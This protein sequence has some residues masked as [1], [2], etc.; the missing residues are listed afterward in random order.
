[1]AWP[2]GY[3]ETSKKLREYHKEQAM[4]KYRH[5]KQCEIITK[6]L[7]GITQGVTPRQT[8]KEMVESSLLELTVIVR[9]IAIDLAKKWP[10]EEEARSDTW[11]KLVERSEGICTSLCKLVGVSNLPEARMALLE[12]LRELSDVVRL[13]ANRAKDSE[14]DGE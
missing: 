9:D 2:D 12:N 4:N 14:K 8:A 6:R 13:I 10:Q 5:V 1:M 7:I 11:T 3:V